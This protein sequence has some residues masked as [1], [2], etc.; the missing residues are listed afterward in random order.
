MS[1]QFDIGYFRYLLIERVIREYALDV[2][3]ARRLHFVFGCE[4]IEVILDDIK[5]IPR[6]AR[7][8]RGSSYEEVILVHVFQRRVFI[9][10]RHHDDCRREQPLL[11]ADIVDEPDV[12]VFRAFVDDVPEVDEFKGVG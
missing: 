2:F 7:V 6:H 11:D 4:G 9:V 8:S 3:R 5:F 10:I 1:D 12:R